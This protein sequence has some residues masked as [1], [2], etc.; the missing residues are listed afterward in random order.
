MVSHTCGFF[1]VFRTSLLFGILLFPVGVAGPRT[2]VAQGDPV[3]QAEEPSLASL[4]AAWDRRQAQVKSL[5]MKWTE[6]HVDFENSISRSPSDNRDEWVPPERSEYSGTYE[7]KLS[8]P[9][10]I[11]EYDGQQ[12]QLR[13]APEP[14]KYV[15]FRSLD[16]F[17]GREGRSL[18]MVLVDD[19][20]PVGVIQRDDF[21]PDGRNAGHAPVAWFCRPALM[22]MGGFDAGKLD[23][24]SSR[25]NRDGIECMVLLD[26]SFSAHTQVW[27]AP[28]LDYNVVGVDVKAG[29]ASDKTT[30]EIWV[31]YDRTADGLVVP[32][33]WVFDAA[34]SSGQK[35][36]HI[37]S[38][39]TDLQVNVPIDEAEFRVEFPATTLVHD[40]K[41]DR[42]YL[43]DPQGTTHPLNPEATGRTYQ[44]LR[45][46]STRVSTESPSAY[47]RI[48]LGLNV[49][50]AFMIVGWIV[51]SRRSRARSG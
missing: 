25:M 3:V 44:Q 10:S 34:S 8:G 36:W 9:L 46:A 20:V 43:V 31:A 50:A 45:T 48:L 2:C 29:K 22:E 4:R 1:G 51:Y 21:N 39:V 7:F 6:D 27:V 41:R 49:V 38:T 28:S 37:A 33:S 35:L 40:L 15:P 17:D 23:L 47:K 12:M 11:Y 24:M 13:S 32:K 26:D 42:K 18:R 14:S 16:G 30:W 19:E 5:V